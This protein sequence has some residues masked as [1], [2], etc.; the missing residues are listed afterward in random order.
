MIS[1]NCFDMMQPETFPDPNTPH[2]FKYS[3]VFFAHV[4]VCFWRGELRM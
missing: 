4:S 1:E 2:T 3:V